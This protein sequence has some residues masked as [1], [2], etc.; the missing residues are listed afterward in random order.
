MDGLID[1]FVCQYYE[2][3]GSSDRGYFGNS[4]PQNLLKSEVC[5]GRS[6]DYLYEQDNG[7]ITKVKVC[8]DDGECKYDYS[9]TWK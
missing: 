5:E 3:D 9:Y 6:T 1:S 4:M 7:N 2:K 8:G